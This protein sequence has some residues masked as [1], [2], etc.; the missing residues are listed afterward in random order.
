MTTSRFV[1][2][3]A[4]RTDSVALSQLSQQTWRETYLQDLAMPIPENDVEFYFRTEKSPE[5]YAMKIADPLGATWLIEDKINDE[6]VAFLIV[7]QTEVPHSDFCIGKDGQIEYLYVRRDRQSQGLGQQLMSV[8]LSWMKEQFPERPVWL[9]TSAC[10]LKSHKFYMHYD[11]TI[12][13]DFYS[14]VGE[15]NRH[16]IIMRRV[17]RSS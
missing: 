5:W 3:R 13:G 2:R 6:I 11:F 15:T 10:N 14:S 7:G 8:A 4:I 12:I 9:T 1:L 16:L 17:N